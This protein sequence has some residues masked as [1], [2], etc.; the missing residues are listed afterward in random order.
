[1]N[2]LAVLLKSFIGF[3][4]RS[5]IIPLLFARRAYEDQRCPERRFP[6]TWV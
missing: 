6:K 1:M 5:Y 3:S 2:L 4:S